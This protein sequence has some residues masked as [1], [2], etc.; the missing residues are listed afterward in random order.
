MELRAAREASGK[1]QVQVAKESGVTTVS[2]QRYESEER[3]P[4]AVTAI[5]IAETLGIKSFK[6]F[7]LLFGSTSPDNAKIPSGNSAK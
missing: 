1:T 7:K 3:A 4:S 5:R 6:Q 2:Y